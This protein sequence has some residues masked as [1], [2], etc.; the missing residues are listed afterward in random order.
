VIGVDPGLDLSL[1]CNEYG[2]VEARD[3]EDRDSRGAAAAVVNKYNRNSKL[4]LTQGQS[5]SDV[6]SSKPREQ[7]DLDEM[8]PTQAPRKEFMPISERHL[9]SRSHSVPASASLFADAVGMNTDVRSILPSDARASAFLAETQQLCSGMDTASEVSSISN[10]NLELIKEE[11]LSV[12]QLLRH[13]Y[14]SLSQQNDP[15]G[16]KVSL[17]LYLL[18]TVCVVW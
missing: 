3:L 1:T 9:G 8:Q 17:S 4:V 11:F 12:S 5:Q 13:F 2:Y 6:R 16:G 10:E 15:T 14:V 18:F 7:A